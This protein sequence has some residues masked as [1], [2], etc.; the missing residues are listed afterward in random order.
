[1]D[2]GRKIDALVQPP[3]ILPT[4]LELAAVEASPPQPFQ[5]RSF[6]SILRG[7]TT[8]PLHQVVVSAGMIRREFFTER[9]WKPTT[10]VVYDRRWAYVPIGPDNRGHRR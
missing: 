4:L 6:A 5:G 8:G 9:K 1:M 7:E 3:D 2:R 10:P